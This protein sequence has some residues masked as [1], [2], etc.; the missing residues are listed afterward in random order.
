M[1]SAVPIL[2]RL[3][4]EDRAALCSRL[5]TRR[6]V[7]GEMIIS[8]SDEGRDVFFVLEG[9][10][11]V[12]LVSVEG[13]SVDF[14][15]IVPGDMFGELAA[16][17]GQVR[18]A[19]V[20]A[21]EPTLVGRLGHAEFRQLVAGHDELMWS[22]LAYF[23]MQMRTLTTRIFEYS[24]LL[25]RERLVRELVRLAGVDGTAENHAVISPAPTHFELAARISTHREA[26][27]RE[28]STLSKQGLVKKASGALYLED[29]ATLQA[30]APIED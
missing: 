17:D 2:D 3:S 24:T 5:T 12:T 30:L 9:R 21:L 7:S 29:I 28:M 20:T 22:L 19:S 15:E 23:S 13:K 11:R 26:V 10:A 1:T 4:E 14:R 27:S 25:V 6:Y 18:S 16:I 8:A